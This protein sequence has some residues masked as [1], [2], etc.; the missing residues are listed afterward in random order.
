MLRSQEDEDRFL[1][2]FKDI[3][4]AIAGDIMLTEIND[5][6]F[7][8][9]LPIHRHHGQ[10]NARSGVA[11]LKKST[12]SMTKPNPTRILQTP[13]SFLQDQILGDEKTDGNL[14]Y[15]T[16]MLGRGSLSVPWNNLA[17]SKNWS[18]TYLPIISSSSCC[19]YPL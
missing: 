1:Y 18:P 4:T 13:Q 7:I 2:K 11:V 6:A 19:K 17:H 9:F 14:G 15:R 8:N 16:S 10:E 5:L 3:P 12:V